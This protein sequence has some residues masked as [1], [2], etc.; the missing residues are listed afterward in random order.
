MKALRSPWVTGGLVV[1]AVAVVGYQVL[2]NSRGRGRTSHAQPA[3]P[4]PSQPAAAAPTPQNSAP[5]RSAPSKQ[6]P[7]ASS[8]AIDREYVALH[9]TNWTETGRRD[10][11]L[12]HRPLNQPK[13]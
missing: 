11:F 9:F 8:T 13:G 1:V 10:P 6:K 7:A 5:A 3:A 2:S 12:L 4:S